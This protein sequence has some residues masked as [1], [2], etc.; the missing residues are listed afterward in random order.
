VGSYREIDE[1]KKD[2]DFVSESCV[3]FTITML[4]ST[5]TRS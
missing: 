4:V 1:K 2:I 5:D 3:R